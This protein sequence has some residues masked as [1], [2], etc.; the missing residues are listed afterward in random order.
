MDIHNG[1][2]KRLRDIF[3]KKGID[4][5]SDVNILEL[6]LFYSI[7]RADTNPIAHSLLEKFGSLSAVFD[8]DYQQL[9]KVEGIGESSAML[10]KF[11]P[12]L[13]RAYLDDKYAEGQVLDTAEK[14]GE[15]LLPKYVDKINEV[16][17]MICLD[18]KA[19]LINCKLVFEGSINSAQISVRKIVEQAVISN[20]SSVIISHNHP[21]GL[22]LPSG[23]DIATTKKIREAL[24]LV[25]IHLQDHIIVAQ[26]DFVSLAESVGNMYI[27]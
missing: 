20:A 15:F 27:L 10:I 24:A 18:N 12:Q 1:H 16:V 8:A 6:L 4:A 21:A 23:E 3:C 5:L 25:S 17:Y 22:A 2:R 19:K 14:A 11:I 26:H 7:P 13:A 9:L